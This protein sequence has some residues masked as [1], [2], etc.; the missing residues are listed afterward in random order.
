LFCPGFINPVASSSK[1]DRRDVGGHHSVEYFR[2]RLYIVY[3]DQYHCQRSDRFP[4]YS[5]QAQGRGYSGLAA[6]YKRVVLFMA[7]GI[8]YN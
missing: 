1:G 8:I 5:G 7:S 2:A 6:Y 3:R 4:V